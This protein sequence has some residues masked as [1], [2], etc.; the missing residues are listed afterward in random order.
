MKEEKDIQL[1]QL[2]KDRASFKMH[3]SIY[4]VVMAMLW[5]VWLFSGGTNIHP[6]PIYP[7]IGWGIGIISNYFSVYKFNST[8]E[9]EYE[10]LKGG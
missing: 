8:A 6:W 1:W 10:K 4:F 5:M 7:T 3:L 9:K 2:A